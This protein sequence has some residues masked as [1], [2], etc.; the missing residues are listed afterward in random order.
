MRN[1]IRKFIM[2]EN[3]KIINYNS[4]DGT[5]LSGTLM[6]KQNKNKS[7]IIMC[8]GLKTDREEYGDFS[9]LSQTLLEN[10]YDT[11]RF[12]FRAHG[13]SEGKDIEMTIDGLKKDL[14]ATLWL[15]QNEG[16]S[17]LGI[18]GA[19]F[20]ASILSLINYAYFPQVKK[21]IVYSGSI[22]NSNGNPKGSLGIL[23]YKKALTDGSVDIKSKTTE[24]IMTLSK[25]FMKETRELKPEEKIKKINIPILFLQG[26]EDK[27]TPYKVNKNIA[28]QCKEAYFVTIEGASH[29]L[30]R[31]NDRE[32]AVQYILKFL[33]MEKSQE[34][35]DR[36]R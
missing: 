22:D 23:N 33:Q 2:K 1:L 4:I 20:E 34:R 25:T 36:D 19:S 30:H 8:H 3:E 14:E 10:G 32:V 12:D 29:G 18:L 13:K 28:E 15:I 26:T 7:C 35:E 27:T 24:K 21:L 31:Q 9:K 17:Q 16:Y 6:R 5:R 11:F